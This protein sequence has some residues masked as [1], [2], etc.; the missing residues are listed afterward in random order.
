MGGTI[1]YNLRLAQNASFHAFS[2][3]A[4]DTGLRPGRYALL[5][6]ISDNP[7]VSQ[8][9]LSHAVGREKSTLTPILGDL[10][11]RGLIIR[12]PDPLDRRG[13]RL[14]LTAAGK[15][16]LATLAECAARHENRLN[17]IVGPEQKQQLLM[18]LGMIIEALEQDTK[19]SIP[20]ADEV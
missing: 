12:E 18:L 6:H 14:S 19:S 13:R 20:I 16:K 9:L 2:E 3:L 5:Q 10:E 11:R 4:G 15:I 17:A 7:G 1:G 8:T